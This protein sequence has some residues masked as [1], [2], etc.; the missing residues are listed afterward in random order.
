MPPP[1]FRASG[2]RG[3]AHPY[4]TR[5]SPTVYRLRYI[6]YAIS[7]TVHVSQIAEYLRFDEEIRRYHKN[8]QFNSYPLGYLEF[9]R[10]WNE[11][12]HPNDLR[13]LSILRLADDPNDN[14]IEPSDH[15]LH[16]S[17][18]YI[19]AAQVGLTVD[20]E[21]RPSAASQNNIAHEYANLMAEKQRRQREFIEERRQKRIRAF[22]N[23]QLSSFHGPVR[24]SPQPTANRGTRPRNR[25][26]NRNKKGGLAKTTAAPSSDATTT[27][28]TPAEE[29]ST[30]PNDSTTPN[31]P[32]EINK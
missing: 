17:D 23:G 5:L 7:I 22:D 12:T 27:K 29:A 3:I 18:F 1:Q 11:G 24:S 4:F 30:T 31:E 25:G 14:E 15:P 26:R 10:I 9:S 32:M 2:P 28:T 6:D 13:R 21:F 16:I 8:S 19:T 20:D